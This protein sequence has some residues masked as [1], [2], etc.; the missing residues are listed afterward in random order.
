MK[1]VKFE[2]LILTLP[3]NLNEVMHCFSDLL[4]VNNSKN[5]IG[6][7]NPE[8]LLSCMK[9]SELYYYY[10]ENYYNF[11]DGIGLI[12]AI[13]KKL[14]LKYSYQ[15]RFTGTDFFL[16]LPNIPI[17]VFLFGSTVV[18]IENAKKNIENKY[19]HV[20]IVGAISGYGYKNTDVVDEINKV[21]PDI[22][23]VCLG[24]PKQEMWISEYQ[25]KIKCKL[26]FG[27]GG[28]I[29]FW[30]N[31]VKRAPVFIQKMN[32]EWFFR[33]VTNFTFIR[34]KRQVKLIKFYIMYNIHRYN[35]YEDNTTY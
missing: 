26:V 3:N 19:N 22:V 2:E 17:R 8:I 27:N 5:R 7:I 13:N 16:Y 15:N 4:S 24:F 33:L 31:K 1:K 21:D 12:K 20:K 9:D 6:F 11:V 25:N 32:L 34:L 23:I 35:I 29:D 14:K 10:K 30:S 28:A 18:N